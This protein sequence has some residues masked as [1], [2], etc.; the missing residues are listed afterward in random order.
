M[1]DER[2]VEQARLA[3]PA[4]ARK[5]RHSP[6][7]NRG[8]LATDLEVPRVTSEVQRGVVGPQL[9]LQST[10]RFK[11]STALRD[12]AR[13]TIERALADQL[14]READAAKAKVGVEVARD[15]LAVAESEEKRLEAWIGYLTLT[16]PFDGVIVVRN[17]NTFDFVL[18][19]TGDPTA[20]QRSPDQSAGRAAPIYVVDRT[21]VVRI[22][23]D[24]PERD[25]SHVHIGTKATVLARAFRDQVLAGTV[26][27]TAWALN[28][29]SR[30][31]SP[32]DLLQPRCPETPGMFHH[33]NGP[34]VLIG[35]APGSGRCRWKPSSRAATR[36]S[37]GGT[38][39][40][41]RRGS[42]SRRA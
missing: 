2:W 39:T 13:S 11:S 42:K 31:A 41:M 22:F 10:N 15:R 35:A 4:L 8:R 5:E 9:L 17:A 33:R 18:P 38:T 6:V 40:A 14:A 32:T 20:L 29:K 30:M 27:R 7:P 36:P 12:A 24:I 26:T 34:K 1:S 19:T 16:A 21:D 25:A 37:A 3:N 23:V 28:V